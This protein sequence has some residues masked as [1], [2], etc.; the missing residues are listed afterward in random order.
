MYTESTP[1]CVH[2]AGQHRSAE[3]T[4]KYLRRCAHCKGTHK[5]F[6]HK[7]STF[8]EYEKSYGINNNKSSYSEAANKR[9]T[10]LNNRYS[11]DNKRHDHNPNPNQEI[12]E[13]LKTIIKDQQK[14]I[15][16]LN[17]TIKTLSNKLEI[18]EKRIVM[19]N[20]RA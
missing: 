13:D 20:A 17:N 5:A 10:D 8:V 7:C 6:D 3:C 1:I 11:Q 15:D 4:N 19:N 2:C 12:I 9:P 16:N 18:I 14:T